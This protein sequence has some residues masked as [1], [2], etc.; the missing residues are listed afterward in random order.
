MVYFQFGA[1][2][3]PHEQLK[4]LQWLS[5]QASGSYAYE[6]STFT[7]LVEHSNYC[8]YYSH[9]YAADAPRGEEVGGRGGG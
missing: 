2:N 9:S 6:F 3:S 8:Y 5:T 1:N 7:P 4:G